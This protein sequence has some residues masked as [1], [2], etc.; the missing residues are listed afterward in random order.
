MCSPIQFQYKNN[1]V[2]HQNCFDLKISQ[3]FYNFLSSRLKMSLI[4]RSHF[5]ALSQ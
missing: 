1:E 5:G 3:K 2:S 4:Q